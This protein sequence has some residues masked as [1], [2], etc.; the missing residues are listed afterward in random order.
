MK[1]VRFN[2]RSQITI[3]KVFVDQLN[4]KEGDQFEVSLDNGRIILEPTITILRS[5]LQ[6]LA[7]KKD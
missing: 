6:N 7:D 4:L 3:P 5:E 1:K 2:K